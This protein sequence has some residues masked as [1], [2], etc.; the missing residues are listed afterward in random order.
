[1]KRL[2]LTLFCAL[3]LSTIGAW[4]DSY[5]IT[6]KTGSN[7][8]Q[9]SSSTK[10]STIVDA[11][12]TKYVSSFT[13]FDKAIY[14]T[15]KALQLGNSRTVGKITIN[16]AASYQINATKITIKAQKYNKDASLNISVNSGKESST[17][18]L[19]ATEQEYTF[20][21]NGTPI[22][23]IALAGITERVC[24]SS[25]TILSG[26][27]EVKDLTFSPL[28]VDYGD[29]A[30][31]SVNPTDFAAGVTELTLTPETDGIVT[32]DGLTYMA[33]KAG[34]TKVNV[35]WKNGEKYLAGDTSFEFTVNTLKPKLSWSADNVVCEQGENVTLPNLSNTIASLKPVV[36]ST[37]TAVAVVADDGTVSLAGGIGEAEITATI[38][39]VEGENEAA[40]ASYTISVTEKGVLAAPVFDPNGGTFALD[41]IIF[42]ITAKAGQIY[43]GEG[44]TKAD[45]TELYDGGFVIETVGDHTYVAYAVDGERESEIATATF[46]ITK[47][48]PEFGYAVET[49]TVA[50]G[51]DDVLPML[52]NPKNLAY[53]LTSSNPEVVA[54]SPVGDGTL[55]VLAEGTTTITAKFAGDDS[56]EA[57]TASYTLTVGPAKPAVETKT[58][59]F[60]FTKEGAYGMKA[61]SSEIE[62]NTYNET[63]QTPSFQF[64]NG[65]DITITT[66]KGTGSGT[67]QWNTPDKE[68]KEARYEWRVMNGS[69]FT[70][71]VPD[72]CLIQS[73]EFT[74]GYGG[75]D[76]FNPRL[77]DNK[78]ASLEGGVKE[79]SFNCKTYGNVKRIDLSQLTVTYTKPGAP[80][81]KSAGL[82]FS[83]AEREVL[84]GEITPVEGVS[85]DADAAAL[86]GYKILDASGNEVESADVEPSTDAAGMV[87]ILAG[88]PGEYTLIAYVAPCRGFIPAIAKTIVS[89]RETICPTALYM[90]GHFCDRYYKLDKPVVMQKNGK[91]FTATG[92]LIGGNKNVTD[93]D[94]GYVFTTHLPQ[95]TVSR[96]AHDSNW[97]Q[98]TEGYVYHEGGV[99][100]AADINSQ[101]DLTPYTVDKEGL[102]DITADFSDPAAPDFNAEYIDTTTGIEGVSVSE[103]GVVEY[104]DLTGRR[105]ENPSTGVYIRRTGSEIQKIMLR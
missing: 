65:G 46:T 79:I 64:T 16:V 57:A 36:T 8:N 47:N 78:W 23:T 54:L 73:V 82:S 39:A 72:G 7:T 9:I 77:T 29:I 41:D 35:F 89:A 42:E 98:F 66:N 15:T 96:A 68:T 49:A 31:L 91:I 71:S 25:I 90:H 61:H 92:I 30:K 13:D 87:D 10:V 43:Y 99:A 59:T 88:E 50:L 86:V 28:S 22:K 40:T 100:K 63:T 102:Y 70:I 11:N 69:S 76:A 2:L 97:S 21:L 53:T 51:S 5:T 94:L 6:F 55:W 58:A 27:T 75:G 93:G 14:G 3:A 19:T 80:S 74:I 12:S 103:N 81:A 105:V 32:F 17:G 48:V 1:M 26:P 67:R 52:N 20:D 56:T 104:F 83:D 37:N 101:D 95:S 33:K 85:V 44:T 60:D 24:I 84:V 38:A 34:T 62:P 4:G 18:T 45:A